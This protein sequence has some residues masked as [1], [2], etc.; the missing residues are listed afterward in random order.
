M[1]EIVISNTSP[2]FYLHR[3]QQLDLLQKLYTNIVVPQAVEGR[4]GSWKE[5]GK[6]CSSDNRLSLDRS[7]ACSHAAPAGTD[8][9]LW[10]G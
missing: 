9:R 3:L 1:P 7:S 6:G 5:A 10:P 8:G 2:L 4:I